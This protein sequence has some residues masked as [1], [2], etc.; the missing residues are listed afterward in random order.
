MWSLSFL[1]VTGEAGLDD[2]Q[3]PPD[4]PSGW[5]KVSTRLSFPP[6]AGDICPPQPVILFWEVGVWMMH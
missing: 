5:N 1:S 3:E 4:L 6:W 2:L